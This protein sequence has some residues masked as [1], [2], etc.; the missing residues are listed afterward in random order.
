MNKVTY[1]ARVTPANAGWYAIDFPDLPGT[2]AQCRKLSEVQAKAEESLRSYLLAA[3]CAGEEVDEP[4]L[5]LPLNEEDP[6]FSRIYV[7]F[8]RSRGL[9]LPFGEY[10]LP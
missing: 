6:V 7:K 9:P 8:H 1:P 4:S 3:K 10:L 5:T 2:H